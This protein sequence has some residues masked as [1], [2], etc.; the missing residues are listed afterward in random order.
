[1][2]GGIRSIRVDVDEDAR[3][4]T[5]RRDADY[6]NAPDCEIAVNLRN[7]TSNPGGVLLVGADWDELQGDGQ[8]FSW[9]TSQEVDLQVLGRVT[10]PFA[11]G[12]SVPAASPQE[13]VNAGGGTSLAA[14]FQI[15]EDGWLRPDF[16]Q[17]N[18]FYVSFR[19]VEPPSVV[20]H[21]YTDVERVRTILRAAENREAGWHS[22]FAGRVDDCISSAEQRIDA[23]CGRRFDRSAAAVRTFEVHNAVAV[24]L[25][26]IDLGQPVSVRWLRRGRTG[27]AGSQVAAGNY[28]IRRMTGYDVGRFLLPRRSVWY[29]Q[30]GDRLEVSAH[31]GWPQVPAEVRDYAGRLASEI[32]NFDSATAGL[33][34]TGDGAMYGATP[35]KHIGLALRHL[36]TGGVR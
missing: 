29:P 24:Q 27:A 28:T 18:D 31:F 21:R 3:G 16:T 35:G 34:G 23:Y 32:F 15:G 25:D 19:T 13:P 9:D 4:A 14:T 26:D 36:K 33:V 7:V 5:I 30:A 2:T 6:D 1:M 10:G 8:Q 12:M 22:N 11:R 20:S 17:G